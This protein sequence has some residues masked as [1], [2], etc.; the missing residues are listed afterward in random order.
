VADLFGVG[1]LQVLEDGLGLF[2]GVAGGVVIAGGVVRVAEAVELDY[3]IT[4][5]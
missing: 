3:W 5:G 2:P 4:P 1:V